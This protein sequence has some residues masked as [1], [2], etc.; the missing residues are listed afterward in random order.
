MHGRWAA[1]AIGE[2][3]VRSSWSGAAGEEQKNIEGAGQTEELV[4]DMEKVASEK[5]EKKQGQECSR[6]QKRGELHEGSSTLPDLIHTSH[7]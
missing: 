3:L 7:S 4:Q 1:G 5:L 6:N 2:M